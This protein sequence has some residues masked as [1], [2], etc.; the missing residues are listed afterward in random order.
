MLRAAG[1]EGATS[2]GGRDV[3]NDVGVEPREG[4]PELLVGAGG[5]VCRSER[6]EVAARTGREGVGRE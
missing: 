2:G 4:R 1:G 3:A 5:V 6:S